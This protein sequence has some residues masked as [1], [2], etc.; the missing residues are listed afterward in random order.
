MACS[1]RATLAQLTIES[2]IQG[3]QGED[4]IGL[5]DGS[6]RDWDGRREF[7]VLLNSSHPGAIWPLRRHM[8]KYGDMLVKLLQCI[9]EP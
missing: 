1:G 5:A 3:K 7:L 4:N 6:V 2:K 9:G 8:E